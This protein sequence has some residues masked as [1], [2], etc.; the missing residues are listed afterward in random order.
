MPRVGGGQ[1]EVVSMPAP[2]PSLAGARST[3][4]DGVVLTVPGHFGVALSVDIR[5]AGPEMRADV[6][7]VLLVH[8]F[9]ASGRSNWAGTGWLGG[10]HRAGIRTITVDLR[11]H[12]RSTKPVV[13]S[14]YRLEILLADLRA[15]LAAAPDVVGPLPVVDLIGYSLG[16]RLVGELVAAASVHDGL[17]AVR[18]AVIGGYD[19]RPLFEGL[20][21]RQLA[22]YREAVAGRPAPEGIGSRTAA[23]A[24]ADRNNDLAA[25]SA[26]V[27]GMRIDQ[28]PL[29]A[30]VVDVPT[31]VVAGDRDGIT[32]DTQ[33]WAAALP[34]GRHLS[35]PGRDHISTVTSA[36]FRAAAVDFLLS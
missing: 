4:A 10:L 23:I 16:G 19:G 14:A 8:G 6:P 7:P 15:V 30:A 21:D 9:G 35:I 3:S 1:D 29:P 17:P 25:L 31:L 13:S 2:P 33:R 36:L 28:S 18:R 12:G 5:P 27:T 32:A 11:G 34:D 24:L 20:D 22:A 26:L